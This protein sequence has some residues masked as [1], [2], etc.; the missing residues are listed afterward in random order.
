VVGL[1]F[2]ILGDSRGTIF[3]IFPEESAR[4]LL[5]LLGVVPAAGGEC[6]FEDE[7]AASSLTEVGNILASSYLTAINRLTGL[8][9][10]PSVPSFAYDMAGS[11]VDYV[12]IEVGRISDRALVVETV[13][14]G[15]DNRLFGHVFL[16]PDPHSLAVILKT[17]S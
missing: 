14:L 9:L 11:I 13:F 7:M 17:V 8:V 4:S 2:R 15:D 1:H 3:M 12:L 10:L 5:A 16:I 6:P